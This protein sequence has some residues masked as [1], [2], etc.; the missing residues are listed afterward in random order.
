MFSGIFFY[1]KLKAFLPL[2]KIYPVI[3]P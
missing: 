2:T 3:I 1:E